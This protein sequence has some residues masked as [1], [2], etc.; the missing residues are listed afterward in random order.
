M[1][2]RKARARSK[3]KAREKKTD[4]PVTARPIGDG[5]RVEERGNEGYNGIASC[6]GGY[7]RVPTCRD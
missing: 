6:P 2:T 4:K 7:R 1:V 5:F 3:V